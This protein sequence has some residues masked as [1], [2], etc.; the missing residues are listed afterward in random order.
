ME[1]LKAL[2]ITLASPEEIL[3]WSYGEVMKPETINYRTQKPEREG[4]FSEVIF[5][6]EKDYECYCGKYKKARFQGV[7]CDRCGVEITKAYVRRERMGHISLAAPVSHIWFLRK[8]PS[9][10]SLFFSISISDL[11]NVIYF[12]SYVILKV[13]NKIKDIAIQE[14]KKS[15]EQTSEEML[16]IVNKISEGKIISESELQNI[17]KAYPKLI[18]TSTGAEA[19]RILAERSDL[20]QMQKEL[21]AEIEN[22]GSVTI[23]QKLLSRVRLIEGFIKAGIRPEWM[24]ITMLPIIPPELRPMIALDGGR[25][26]SSDVNDL[27][28]RV[29]N[30]N[31]RLKRLI[32]LQAPEVIIRNEKRMLQEAVDALIDNSARAG[33]AISSTTGQKRVLKSIADMIRG[34]QGRFRRN[35]LGKR[36][37]YSARSVIVSGPNLKMHQCGIP[38]R[39]ALELFKPFVIGGLI[40]Q[41]FA[42]NI[43]G[44]NHIIDLDRPEVWEILEN[45]ISNKYILLNRAPTLHRLGIQAFQPILIEGLAIQL[46]PLVCVAF[47]ADFDGDQMS[48]HIPLSDEAQKEAKELMLSTQNYLRPGTGTPIVFPNLEIVLGIYFMTEFDPNET[49]KD[50]YFASKEEAKLAYYSRKIGLRAPINVKINKEIVK[51]SVGRIIFSNILP[52]GKLINEHLDKSKLREIV[53]ET[54]RKYS[55]EEVEK[56]LDNIK[57]TGF[58]YAT[59]SGITWSSSEL[60]IPKSKEKIVK[61]AEKQTLYLLEQYNNG[62]LTENERRSRAIK[63]WL[64]AT[65][66]ILLAV[67]ETLKD[68]YSVYSIINSGARGSWDQILQMSGMKGLVTNP[69]QEIIE[70]PIKMSYKEGLNVLEYFI[71]THGAR[72]G[73]IDT[74]LKTSVAGY[75]TR[76]LA[77]LAHDVIIQEED[78]G[79]KEGIIFS[80]VDAKAVLLELKNRIFGRVEVKTNR[81]ID[82]ELSEKWNNDKKIESV[83]VRSPITCESQYGMCQMCYGYDLTNNKLVKIGQAVGIIA[84][85]SIGEPATQLTLKTFHMGGIAGKVDITQGLPRIEEIFEARIPKGK[86]VIASVTGKITKIEQTTISRIVKIK[87]SEGQYKDKEITYNIPLDHNLF[88]KQDEL[89]SAGDSLC[90]GPV[91]LHE[92]HELKG[93]REVWRYIINEVQYNYNSKGAD[94]NDK[95]IEIITRKMFYFIK[96]INPGDTD[97]AQGKIVEYGKFSFENDKIKAQ[98]KNPAKG[99]E[100]LMGVIKAASSSDSFLSAASFQ[101]TASALINAAIQ[102]KEDPLRGL[103]ENVIIGRLIPAGTGFKRKYRIL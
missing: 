9:K 3:K 67:K 27:Y 17:N 10:M 18:E 49:G 35:L 61:E 65:D 100:V 99:K 30:R 102:G 83:I 71:S 74:A 58:H 98:G 11:E 24:F 68:S 53:A 69:S 38:K 8:L 54:I 41:G 26:A 14:L 43:K 55:S 36:V 59:I 89:V 64:D 91:D 34:K 96:I 47:N 72:K 73:S 32:N 92:L 52:D 85:Q 50:K 70:L 19:L 76:R 97:M 33:R 28:R 20:K 51:T 56:I 66:K 5:G 86:G 94:V 90:E 95:Y 101:E 44:A 13:D 82:K 87:A 81:L 103:K 75:L 79:T 80:R 60:K 39:I 23:R 6:P 77:D 31:N 88:V 29:I 16:F 21:K 93:K 62:F 42:Y 57:D 63:V 4:L 2:K 46:H 84:A 25:F 15:K 45:T 48:I 1:N 7:I 40:K 22:S 12:I 78:C 37:D